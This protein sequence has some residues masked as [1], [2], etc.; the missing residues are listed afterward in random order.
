MSTL[1]TLEKYYSLINPRTFARFSFNVFPVDNTQVEN[2]I[3]AGD[4]LDNLNKY[5]AFYRPGTPKITAIPLIIT[6]GDLR[7]HLQETQTLSFLL[8]VENLSPKSGNIIVTSPTGY[9]ASLS[10]TS[11]FS[12][13]L[14]IPYTRGYFLS[15]TIYVKFS[16]T[17]AQRYDSNLIV[18][19]A[20]AENENIALIGGGILTEV[21]VDSYGEGHQTTFQ[22]VRNEDITEIGQ[23]FKGDGSEISKAKFYLKKF[24]TTLN[25]NWRAK[26]YAH[27]GIYGSS[28]LPTGSPLATSDDVSASGV[29]TSFSVLSALFSNTYR[30][31]EDVPYV[32]T[33]EYLNGSA[34]SCIEFGIDSVTKSHLG[35]YVYRYNG[36]WHYDTFDSIFYV[37]G[38][39]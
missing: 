34:G 32:I 4:L 1:Q 18:S 36:V 27:S 33:F 16:P 3:V 38:M 9:Q 5:Y 14:Q 24:G 7:I 11:G 6:F 31:V 23:S 21:T 29:T 37:N 39:I 30:L 13:A 26:L 8:S 20:N 25:G 35:N 2:P 10:E 17:I 19:G 12:S 15:K 22:Y 28:G